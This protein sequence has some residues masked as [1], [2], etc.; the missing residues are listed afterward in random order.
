M[1]RVCPLIHSHPTG[2][3]DEGG[4][5]YSST[6]VGRAI[7]VG[8]RATVKAVTL[9]YQQVEPGKYIQIDDEEFQNGWTELAMED[10]GQETDTYTVTLPGDLQEHRHL[11]RYQITVEDGE[12]AAITVPYADDGQPNFAYFCYGDMPAWTGA[13]EPGETEEVT[14]GPELL[15]SV[16]VYQL[17]TSKD[18]HVD[19]LQYTFTYMHAYRYTC[20]YT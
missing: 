19:S 11:M 20:V 16:P 18:N 12:G 9:R 2:G 4:D 1:C 3:R 14:Y 6:Y 5:T 8:R 13:I 15:Q 10:D 17:I 7:A